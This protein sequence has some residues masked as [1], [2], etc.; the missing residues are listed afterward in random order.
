MVLATILELEVR[1][2]D[3]VDNRARNQHLT[4]ASQA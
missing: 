2:G 3:K 1:T 4:R